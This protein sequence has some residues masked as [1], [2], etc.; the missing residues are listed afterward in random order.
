MR[1]LSHSLHID[2]DGAWPMETPGVEAH[3]DCREWGPRL[4][5]SA[6]PSGIEA[7]YEFVRAHLARFTLFGSGDF[8]HL[9]ALRLRKIRDPFTL[10]SFDNHP[11]WDIRPPRWGCGTWLNRA[12]ELPSLRAAA[13][14][15]CGNFELNWPGCLFVSRAALRDRRL[16]VWPWT[17]RLKPSGRKRWP[18]M[19]RDDWREKFSAFVRQHSGGEIYVT[20]DLDC[21]D[22]SESVT[23]WESGLF[24]TDDIVWALG[25]IRAHAKIIGGDVCGAFSQPH[26]ARWAQRIA[27]TFDHPRLDGITEST[28]KDRNRR[29]LE[30]IWKALTGQ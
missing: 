10:I 14:W 2:L 4:R 7:F 28:A 8:H 9:T 13:I 30:P 24:T 15:G 5:Y 11:D 1:P 22:K 29:A 23:N 12:L 25:E 19:Q 16:G 18:G 21:L 3:L 20:V 6:T 27:A 17:E 26:F